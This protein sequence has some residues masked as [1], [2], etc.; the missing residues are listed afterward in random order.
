MPTMGLGKKWHSKVSGKSKQ[1]LEEKTLL[2]RN[3][4]MQH[5][6]K[7]NLFFFCGKRSTRIYGL[8]NCFLRL[9]FGNAK[10]LGLST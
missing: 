4:I 10:K 1:D 9:I 3:A 6:M 2:I 5:Q 7:Y 8:I